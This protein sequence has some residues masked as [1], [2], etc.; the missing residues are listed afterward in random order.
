MKEFVLINE[1]TREEHYLDPKKKNVIGRG[2]SQ[3]NEQFFLTLPDTTVS[4][5][6]ATITYDEKKGLWVFK[7]H[8]KFGS[9]V[10]DQLIHNG[11]VPIEHKDVINLGKGRFQVYD[12]YVD[13]IT[14]T[15]EISI[16]EL[17]SQKKFDPNRR[18]GHYPEQK[19]DQAKILELVG[20]VLMLVTFI[21]FFMLMRGE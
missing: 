8:S 10:N 17:F 6:H 19:N 2:L 3:K 7:D 13:D 16:N 14:G 18:T 11:Q 15:G 21:L 12:E 4:K 9:K 20:I 1:L 5:L